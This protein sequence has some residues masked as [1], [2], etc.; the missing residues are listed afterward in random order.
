MA[1]E[2]DACTASAVLV[3]LALVACDAEPPPRELRT[4]HPAPAH[5]ARGSCADVLDT[6]VCWDAECPAGACVVERVLPAVPAP[7]PLGW[8]CI[9]NAVER[10]CLDRAR[11]VGPFTCAG[12]RC[13]QLHP[14]LPGDGEWTCAELAGATLCVGGVGPAG[15]VPAQ[16]EPGFICGERRQAAAASHADTGPGSVAT[17]RGETVCVDL[18][19]DFPDSSPRGWRCRFEHERGVRRIC[20]KGE[21]A[22]A[23]G[24]SCSASAP[25]IDGLIC[26]ASRCVPHRPEVSCW[27]DT[28]CAS[29]ACRLGTCLVEAG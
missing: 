11:G 28:D 8:R 13:T 29:G 23:L 7:S 27:L 12:D 5:A 9:E 18:S 2:P 4:L 26:A 1:E 24:A 25:C 10:V 16:A 3:L 20:E 6:R 14:R 17:G 22:G 15:V 19:P 21:T